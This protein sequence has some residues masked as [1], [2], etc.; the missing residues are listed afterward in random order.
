MFLAAEMGDVLRLLLWCGVLIA[1]VLVAYVVIQYIRKLVLGRPPG[2]A[3]MLD[4]LERMHRGGL[5][6]EQEYRQAR[7]VLM[8]S[9]GLLPP[10]PASPAESAPPG[11]DR[12][13]TG[14]QD[15]QAGV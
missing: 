8:R 6:T 14:E 7:R 4:E 11:P 10:E 3:D 12:P 1:F 15:A 9:Q 5:M 13:D 2:P